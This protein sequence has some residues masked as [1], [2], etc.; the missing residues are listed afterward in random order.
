MFLQ[1]R[2]LVPFFW[3]PGSCGFRGKPGILAGMHNL[4][5]WNKIVWEQTEADP[6]KDLHG[7][8]RKGPRGLTWESFNDCVMFHLLTV[9]PNNA[10]EQEK[11]PF[12]TCSRSPR[13]LAYVS[14]YSA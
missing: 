2:N 11:Y 1:K 14:L 9:F 5:L 10:A 12:P 7:V 13:G 8:S 6:F 4:D 3:N